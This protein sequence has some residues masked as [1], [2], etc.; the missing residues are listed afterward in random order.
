MVPG[1][2]NARQKDDTE[3]IL[4]KMGG[5]ARLGLAVEPCRKAQLWSM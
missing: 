2:W 1:Q 4:G 3:G 5:L